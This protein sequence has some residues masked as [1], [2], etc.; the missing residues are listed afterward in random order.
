MR[1]NHPRRTLQEAPNSPTQRAT[2]QPMGLS[3]T[4]L[5]IIATVLIVAIGAGVI[6]LNRRRGDTTDRRP[7]MPAPRPSA[8]ELDGALHDLIRQDKKIQAIK[9]LREHTD[10][11]LKQAKEAVDG[12]AAGYPIHYPP[13]IARRPARPQAD[14]ASRVREL[15]EAGRAEQA[16][17]LVR[18]ETGMDEPS[19]TLFVDSL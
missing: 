6:A 3:V 10:L 1:P 9:L 8:Q 4:E 7:A 17:L 19:A 14:L 11:S 18:G 12:L 5:L 15:K 2:I 16:V 13:A